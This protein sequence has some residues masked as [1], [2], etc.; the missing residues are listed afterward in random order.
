MMGC[1]GLD[2]CGSE[3]VK[4]VDSCESGKETFGFYEIPEIY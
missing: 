4:E 1:R 3:Y 2:F